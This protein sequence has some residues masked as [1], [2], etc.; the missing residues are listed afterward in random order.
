MTVT[1]GRRRR[2]Y[3][4]RRQDAGRVSVTGRSGGIR[5]LR[6]TFMLYLLS[7][8]L[9][10]SAINF[11]WSLRMR[12]RFEAAASIAMRNVPVVIS[13]SSVVAGGWRWRCTLTWSVSSLALDFIRSDWSM[14]VASWRAA[15]W[16]LE[17]VSSEDERKT[18]RRTSGRVKARRQAKRDRLS[19]EHSRVTI[20][21][22]TRTRMSPG[23][24]VRQKG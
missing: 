13:G 16:F 15:S 2:S 20:A 21:P 1:V 8:A 6:V 3:L 19:E 18:K 17:R 5:S 4:N 7:G 12:S 10:C 23:A 22:P 9:F 24:P 14:G 11:Q